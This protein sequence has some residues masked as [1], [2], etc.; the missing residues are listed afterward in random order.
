MKK[1]KDLKEICFHNIF[2][3][4]KFHMPGSHGG[5][6]LNS[7]F[8]KNMYRF[9]N[10]E[11]A[12]MDDYHQPKGIIEKG[13][14]MTREIF[15]SN[16]CIYLVNG[17]TAGIIASI[18]Y[19]FNENEKVIVPR[20]SHKSVISGLILAGV[21][22][23]YCTNEYCKELNAFLPLDYQRIISYVDIHRDIKGI[24]LTTPNYLGI[25]V[26]NLKSIVNYCVN[27]NIKV[28]IDEA[29]GSHLYF[30]E[31]NKYLANTNKAD[32]VINSFHKNLNGL[33]QTAVMNINNENIRKEDI[34]KHVTLVTSSSPSYI[35]LASLAYATEDYKNKGMHIFNKS[36]NKAKKIKELLDQYKILYIK[37]CDNRYF[38][39]PTKVVVIFPTSKMAKM[40][41]QDLIKV[42]VFP[43]MI[44]DNKILFNIN[45]RHEDKHLKKMARLLKIIV[46][47]N[48]KNNNTEK[49]RPQLIHFYKSENPLTPRQAFYSKPKE[50]QIDMAE[51]EISKN[52]IIPFPPGIPVVMP[53][54][55]ITKEAIAIIK[56]SHYGV[57]GIKNGMIEVVK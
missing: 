26:K 8:K 47:R 3:R 35:L 49:Q 57:H 14:I 42:R 30:S 23:I 24:I 41:H 53:G 38:L 43:E 21:K 36:E 54:E 1:I 44:M 56:E 32:I 18:S 7:F 27:K 50:V 19:L 48:K 11:V 20:D 46:D 25:G 51:G 52:P 2:G 45:H 22:P 33:T 39:D 37:G 29:H 9:E 13:E 15:Q 6:T 12:E 55:I 40:V 31:Y 34:R 17:A 10:T 28:I 5:E 16:S 4:M